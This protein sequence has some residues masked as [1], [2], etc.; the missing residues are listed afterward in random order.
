LGS[1]SKSFAQ[2]QG[3][4]EFA[5]LVGLVQKAFTH[6]LRH[7]WHLCL[8]ILCADGDTAAFHYNRTACVAG[9]GAGCKHGSSNKVLQRQ[10]PQRLERGGVGT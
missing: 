10:A 9:H 4:H 6:G 5:E 1:R 3:L 7:A 8:Q 2:V